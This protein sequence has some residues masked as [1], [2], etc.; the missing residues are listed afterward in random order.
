MEAFFSNIAGSFTQM[1][2]WELLAVILAIAYLLLAMRENI[3]CWHCALVSTAIYTVL[4]W[5]VSLLMD[6]GLN[7][8]Y[9]GMAVYGWWQWRRGGEQGKGVAVHRCP[10]SWHL[11]AIS[12]IA[13][14]TLISGYFLSTR[15]GAAW[16]YADSFTTWASVFTT[17]LVARKVLENWLYWIVIDSVSIFL[18]IDRELYLTAILFTAYVLICVKGYFMWRQ[19]L[20]QDREQASPDVA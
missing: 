18:Y 17:F 16:P 15:T 13:I 6:S 9:M 3:F 8:Y 10:V 14:A 2:G 12:G 19:H 20:Y 1:L 11:L 5:N 7:V 4:F